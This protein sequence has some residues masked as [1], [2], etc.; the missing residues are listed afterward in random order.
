MTVKR[1]L[2]LMLAL[3]LAPPTYVFAQSAPEPP[4][5]VTRGTGVIKRAPN[6]AFVGIASETRANL[7]AEAQ[8]LSAEAMTNVQGALAKVGLPLGAIKTT[9]YSLEPDLEWS[10]GRS[11]VRGYIAR[12]QIEVQVDDLAKLGAVIDAAGASGATSMS[13][14]RFDLK[15]RAAVEREALQLAVE[16]AM[17]RAKAIAAGA[18]ATLGP[19]LRIQEGTELRPPVQVMQMRAVADAAKATPIE[20]GETEVRAEVS[21]TIR[22]GG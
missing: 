12:N 20:A 7:P 16:D 2:P 4:V 19:I 21:L 3:A 9:G 15:E 11:R 18:R 8:R 10:N 1:L 13:G 6:Q 17:A 14:L 5:I 22:I